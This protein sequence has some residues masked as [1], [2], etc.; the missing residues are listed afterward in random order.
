MLTRALFAL[1]PEKAHEFAMRAVA[2]AIGVPGGR[3]ALRRLC[4]PTRRT[5]VDC[6]G[7]R[8]PGPVGVAA[9]FDKDGR[10]LAELEALGFDFVE[11]GSVTARPWP[12]RPRP[13]VVRLPAQR[14]LLN[15]MGLPS[16][17]A[18]AVAS[19]LA[20]ERE[21][22][23]L[24]V[25]VNVAKTPDPR[26]AGAEAVA[27]YV[28]AVRLLAPVADAVVV[29][30][31]CPNT[32]DGRTFEEPGAMRTLVD[33]VASEAAR[34]GRK[35]LVKLSPDL[36]DEQLEATARAALDGGAC[37]F[38]A[39]NTTRA[40]SRE[41]L[42]RRVRGLVPAGAGGLSGEPLRPRALHT[43]AALRRLGGSSVCILGV[44]GVFGPDDARAFRRAG[45]HAVEVF[46]GFVYGGPRT[47]RRVAAAWQ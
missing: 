39:T 16:E 23:G 43:V 25:L 6:A 45:A 7:I 14:A 28:A 4:G 31:S 21:R 41:A 24:G 17:G 30:A 10:W 27:D 40:W 12:G 46:T 3:R 1:P 20:R 9:G 44:G 35:V 5:P 22:V 2:V 47:A 29:N 33:A 8:L 36:D 19:R 15:W 11:V 18:R 13:R 26:I 42:P 34:R 38:V 37:G 32:G